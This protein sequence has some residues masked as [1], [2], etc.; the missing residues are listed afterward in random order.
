MT[1]LK[2]L[3]HILN[4]HCKAI[5]GRGQPGRMRWILL[6][7][8]APIEI[9]KHVAGVVPKYI[10]PILPKYSP[11]LPPHLPTSNQMMWL[12]SLNG[13]MVSGEQIMMFMGQSVSHYCPFQPWKCL[14]SLHRENRGN[15]T[16]KCISICLS[17]DLIDCLSISIYLW[18]CVPIYLPFYLSVGLSV[19]ISIYFIICISIHPSIYQFV[20]VCLSTYLSISIYLPTYLAVSSE[21]LICWYPS[22]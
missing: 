21:M 7:I 11:P 16:V 6:W 19:Y 9:I 10:M 1:Y 4:L 5:L 3:W 2:F 8:I 17:V 22:E 15:I 13:F 18:N 20:Y 14:C 12:L